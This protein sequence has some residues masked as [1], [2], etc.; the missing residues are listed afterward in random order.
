M[1]GRFAP[2]CQVASR[3]TLSKIFIDDSE[4]IGLAPVRLGEKK[5]NITALSGRVKA[6]PGKMDVQKCCPLHSTLWLAGIDTCAFFIH[7]V[8]KIP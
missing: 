4:K 8:S 3:S 5:S 7:I 2:C 1:E 6:F